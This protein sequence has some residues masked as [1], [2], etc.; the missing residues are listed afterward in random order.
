MT[1][2]KKLTFWWWGEDEAPGLGAWLSRTIQDFE[3]EHPGV[4]IDAVEEEMLE[5]IPR[6]TEAAVAGS[7]PDLQFLWNGIYH[8]ESA[9]RGYLAPL[10]GL[11]PPEEFAHMGATAL[12]WYGGRPYRA[13][14]YLIPVFWAINRR[15]LI[16]AGVSPSEIPPRTWD[17]FISQCERLGAAGT[18]PLIAGDAQGD[19]SV[20]WLTHFLVQTL[21]RPGDVAELVLGGLDWCDP[22]YADPWVRLEHLWRGGH[23]NADAAAIDLWAAWRR[24]CAGGGAFAFAS[25]PMFSAAATALGEDALIAPAPVTSDGPLAGVPIVDT[26]GI[27]I[28][29]ASANQ[30]DAAAL[31]RSFHQRSHL[32]RLWDEV[33]LLPANDTWAGA[34]DIDQPQFR[35]MW[36]WF[37]NG[38]STVYVPDL[39]PVQCH[40]A[41][42]APVGRKLMAEEIDAAGAA[43]WIDGEARRWRREAGAE[44]EHYRAWTDSI[45]L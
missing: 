20:W 30:G 31:L 12:S 33:G 22:R 38:P 14:W 42:V 34:A 45:A 27:G 21:D 5:V 37:A 43:A 25:G 4:R 44:V 3:R 41:G 29:A 28:A 39:I 32:Q 6:F 26:Q 8:I 23:I 11:I 2:P 16:A 9:W 24:F 10:D 17:D 36:D 7:P 15:L 13:G 35:L 19:F 40:F 18:T 1:A